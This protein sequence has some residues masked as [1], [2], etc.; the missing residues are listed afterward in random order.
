ML[1]F[2]VVVRDFLVAL[3]L[4]WAGVTFEP[5]RPAEACQG[6]ACEAPANSIR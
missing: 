3:A 5:Q 6:S 2:L 4:A 1:T